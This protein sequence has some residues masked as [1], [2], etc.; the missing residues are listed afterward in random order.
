MEWNVKNIGKLVKESEIKIGRLEDNGFK[1]KCG[2][3]DLYFKKSH[4]TE[5]TDEEYRSIE[6]A[7]EFENET[8]ALIKEIV[9]RRDA[10]FQALNDLHEILDTV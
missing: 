6:A 9:S 1:S 2:R 3:D 5:L 7:C 10:V 4:G 8:N